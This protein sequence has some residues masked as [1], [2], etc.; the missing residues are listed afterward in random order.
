VGVGTHTG[1][2]DPRAWRG[3]QVLG[4][5]R[6][7]GLALALLMTA[8]AVLPVLVVLAGALAGAAGDADGDRSGATLALG[9]LVALLMA[10]AML[11]TAWVSV[12]A[13]TRAAG[14]Q[15]HPGDPAQAEGEGAG[16]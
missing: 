10:A 11:A 9:V 6:S 1:L 2:A 5:L 8:L 3:W 16:T 7:R 13:M 4:R 12:R 15:P 14:E